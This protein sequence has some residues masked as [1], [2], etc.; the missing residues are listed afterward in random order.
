MDCHNWFG[1]F[2][3]RKSPGMIM[4]LRKS[5]KMRIQQTSLILVQKGT[6]WLYTHTNNRILRLRVTVVNSGLF[7][8][9]IWVFWHVMP[10]WLVDRYRHFG[11]VWHLHVWGL[12]V[13]LP[14]L[15]DTEEGGRTRLFISWHGMTCCDSL[16][17]HLQNYLEGCSNET[18]SGIV[19]SEGVEQLKS[20]PH[21]CWGSH[22]FF[23]HISWW[24]HY[25]KTCTEHSLNRLHMNSRYALQLLKNLCQHSLKR[26][27]QYF[28]VSVMWQWYRK[29]ILLVVVQC[30]WLKLA[31]PFLTV[32]S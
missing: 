31:S 16:Q 12:A 4:K 29:M 21:R 22:P 24:I 13:H 19:P 7:W 26:P 1:F 10:C 3:S 20:H 18:H 6:F 5:L 14:W 25:T 32:A 9:N 28:S 2:P 15:L 17:S 11:E 30:N 8:E 23:W 27:S